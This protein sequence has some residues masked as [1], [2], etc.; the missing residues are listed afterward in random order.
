MVLGGATTSNNT[1]NVGRERNA[2]EHIDLV[3]Q[4]SEDMAQIRFLNNL[5]TERIMAKDDFHLCEGLLSVFIKMT[6]DRQTVVYQRGRIERSN[7][8]T[9][10]SKRD[11]VVLDLGS[12]KETI[13]I[14][15]PSIGNS[16]R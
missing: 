5:E 3:D 9:D 15:P 12:E 16:Y 13:S 2:S 10:M 7:S 8:E 4:T 14:A 11:K 1:S 6:N